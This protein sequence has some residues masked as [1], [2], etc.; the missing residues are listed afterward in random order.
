MAALKILVVDDHDIVRRGICSVL[1]RD[2]ALQV[3][4]EAADGEDA[5]KKAHELQPDLILLDISLPGISGI[6]AAKQVRQIS[7]NSRIITLTQHDSQQ[8]V[9][10]A[11]RAGAV[12]YVLKSE[13]GRELLTAIRTVVGGGSYV[14][15]KA[16]SLGTR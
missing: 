2:P 13:A 12:G 6:E 16:G 10:D 15:A 9:Q 4:A 7:P 1:S 5:V 14:S 11:F 8:M 3:I